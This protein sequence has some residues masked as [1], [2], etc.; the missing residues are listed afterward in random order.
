[1]KSF[2]DFEFD[3]TSMKLTRAGQKVRLTGQALGLLILLI[4]HPAEL[5][6]REEI[7]RSLW[8]NR[9]VEFEHGIDVVLNRLRKALGDNS[10]DPHYIQTVPRIGYRFI[11]E[12]RSETI[13]EH[14]LAG[15]GWI[16]ELKTYAAIALLAGAVGIS[17]CAHSL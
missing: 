11:K 7:Q 13:R 1:M 17:D 6:T 15:I 9:S 8:P 3:E 4:E 10:K 5:V 14:A 2:G 12:V 16:R